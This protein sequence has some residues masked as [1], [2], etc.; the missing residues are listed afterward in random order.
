MKKRILIIQGHPDPDKDHFCIALA[1]EYQNAAVGTGHDVRVIHVA[2]LDFPVL[3][4]ADDYENGTPVVDIR[5]AQEAIRW[6][7]H[8]VII[9]PL[10]FATMPG[11][12]KSFFEQVFR[13]EFL[14]GSAGH[15][16]NRPRIEKSGRVVITMGMPVFAYR[17]G[18]ARGIRSLDSR[19]ISFCGIGPITETLIGG[20][21][22]LNERLA[23]QWLQTVRNLGVGGN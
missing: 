22:A 23:E 14:Y 6:A 11:L 1:T 3:R 12:L 18:V 13:P 15:K 16:K 2:R 10:W 19:V 8:L 20:A 7:N 5:E 21:G 17:L 4:S 9:F